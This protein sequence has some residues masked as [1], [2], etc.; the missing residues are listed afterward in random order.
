MVNGQWS[1]PV[2]AFEALGAAS[3][4]YWL[5]GGPYVECSTAN[6]YVLRPTD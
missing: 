1:K 2:S 3:Q 5:S 4:F 6:P